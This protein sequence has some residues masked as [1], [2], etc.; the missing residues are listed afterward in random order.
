MSSWSNRHITR[1]RDLSLIPEELR[2][3]PPVPRAERTE[4]MVSESYHFVDGSPFFSVTNPSPAGGYN[5]IYYP[6]SSSS[7]TSS[8]IKS[9]SESLM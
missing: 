7:N 9:K 6:A 1:R 3:A 5:P 4:I 8:R 2:P